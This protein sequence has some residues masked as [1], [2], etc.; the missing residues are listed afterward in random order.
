MYWLDSSE[1]GA[2]AFSLGVAHPPGHL[3]ASLVGKACA[4]VPLGPVALKVGL[5]SAL[6]GALAAAQTA[7]LG[8]LVT[9]RTRAALGREAAPS[10]D[11]LAGGAAGLAFGLSYALAFQ[12]V[13]PEVYALSS[14]LVI[15]CALELA[16]YDE[17]GD[18]RRLGAAAL[19]AGLALANHHLLALAIVAPGLLFAYARKPLPPI[20]RVMAIG[21]LGA[22]LIV[23]LPL[24]AARHPLVD[25]GAP[26]DAARVWWLVTAQAFQKAV[27]RGSAGD[28]AAVAFEL[29][30]QLRVAGAL[31][32]IGGA[33][34]LLRTRA[35]RRLGG[36]LVAAAL[37]D[38]AMPA[39]V[40]F[41]PANPDAYGYLAAA[42]ALLA[43]LAVAPLAALPLAAQRSA[44]AGL[45]GLALIAGLLGFPRV[46]L[47]RDWDADRV[48]GGFL[49]GAPPRATVVTSYFQT[50]FGVW[51][52]RAVE[53]ARPDLTLIHRHFLPNPGY[54]DELVRANRDLAPLLGRD[55][56][57]P[58]PQPSLVEY[59]LDLP[60]PLI[61]ESQ[62]IAS[63][64]GV[65]DE[66]QTRRYLAWNA[67]LAAHRACR[68]DDPGA[69]A[70]ALEGAQRWFP[71]L[72]NCD[73]IQA[74]DTIGP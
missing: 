72:Q 61:A 4:L 65:S 51:Y 49:D 33:W 14:L 53:G 26:L 17:S 2:A 8:A 32:A 31:L 58:L 42:V 71:E 47:A 29:T 24:R 59:D 43:V 69:R 46:S 34:L 13:R 73:R 54:R 5:A 55:V 44:A 66:P 64:T 50:V 48:I 15:S 68:I 70:H 3:I 67:F 40:G 11:A 6:C 9:R 60:A 41:D 36:F 23:A 19:W 57:P 21:A 16:R 62:T 25:W 35:L 56:K 20:G 63:P 22:A 52:L 39:L 38:A 45:A 30:A 12:S 28:L 18:R 27:A 1:L 74:L 7:R 10:L 37:L